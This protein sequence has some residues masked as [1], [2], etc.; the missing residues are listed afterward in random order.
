MKLDSIRNESIDEKKHSCCVGQS[1]GFL[2]EMA[3]ENYEKKACRETEAKEKLR[4]DINRPRTCGAK[5]LTYNPVI[6][7]YVYSTIIALLC[8]VAFLYFIVKTFQ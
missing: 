7:L 2:I 3:D 8:N 4:E 6:M 1:K 5:I